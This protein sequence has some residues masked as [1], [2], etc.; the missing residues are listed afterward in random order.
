MTAIAAEYIGRGI[1]TSEASRMLHIPR[2]SLYCRSG[3]Q[4]LTRGRKPSSMT[5]RTGTGET[6]FISNTEVVSEIEH[7]LSREFVCYGY[8]KVT[9]HLQHTGFSINRK[10]VFRLMSEHFVLHRIRSLHMWS[11]VPERFPRGRTVYCE[12]TVSDCASVA[13]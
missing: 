13:R 6:V 8:R 7:L 4:L 9:K 10:K 1:G 3:R 2:C 11:G 5:V 12:Q